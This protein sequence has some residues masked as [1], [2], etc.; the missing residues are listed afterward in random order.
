MKNICIIIYKKFSKTYIPAV[1][2][3]IAVS[4]FSKNCRIA[5]PYLY[6]YPKTYPCFLGY[7][8]SYYSFLILER[9]LQYDRD[10]SRWWQLVGT[11]DAAHVFNTTLSLYNNLKVQKTWNLNISYM[12]WLLIFDHLD[13]LQ[14]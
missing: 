14:T 8:P 9:W 10:C 13:I 6:R 2:V 4:Y 11:P 7:Q 1:P 3:P 5:V 12:R